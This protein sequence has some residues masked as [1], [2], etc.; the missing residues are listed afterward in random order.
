MTP[1]RWEQI[2]AVFREAVRL[3]GE[4]R[5]GYLEKACQ[6]DAEL[7]AEV[8]S[9]LA[10]DGTGVLDGS[11][12]ESL[13]TEAIV[14]AAAGWREG[15]AL[16]ADP[17]RTRPALPVNG[18]IDPVAGWLVCVKGPDQGRDYRIRA[19]HNRIGRDSLMDICVSGDDRISRDTHAVITHVPRQNEF[20][21]SLGPGCDVV[22]LNGEFL[23]R[24]ASLQERDV[25]E[26]GDT[27][28]QF[29]P[30]CGNR[31]QWK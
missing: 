1:K 25:I 24:P 20:R 9:L 19:A 11:A 30:F 12:L 26:L 23:E 2:N 6:G 3:A 15:K 21:L 10:F 28:L 16:P 17:D 8:D 31:F 4:E 14:S 27:G 29:V 13:G 22:Y 18:A 5:R 7:R